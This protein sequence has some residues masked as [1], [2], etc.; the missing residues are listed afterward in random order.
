[1][2]HWEMV[3]YNLITSNISQTP[4]WKQ[5]RLKQINCERI[6]VYIISAHQ[7]IT[8]VVLHDSPVFVAC[9]HLDILDF[10]FFPSTLLSQI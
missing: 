7:R 2:E 1:M 10:L 9:A 6:H 4:T 5:S 8:E 3:E